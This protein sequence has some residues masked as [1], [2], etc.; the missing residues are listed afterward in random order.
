MTENGGHGFKIKFSDD[1]V[2][3]GKGFIKKAG[4]VMYA[5]SGKRGILVYEDAVIL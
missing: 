4:D 1:L 2:P 5:L 3:I